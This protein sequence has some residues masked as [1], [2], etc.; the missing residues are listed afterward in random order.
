MLDALFPSEKKVAGGDEN[1]ATT[2]ADKIYSANGIEI[3][4]GN[5][6]DKCVSYNPT[7]ANNMKMYSW[8]VAQPGNHMYDSYRFG[9]LAPTFYFVYGGCLA[10][11]IYPC[12]RKNK[13]VRIYPKNCG[14]S[15]QIV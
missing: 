4:K 9:K 10:R 13:P 5:E 15:E 6:R 8:C 1:T 12:T 14:T 3:Y 11:C 2:D 7:E